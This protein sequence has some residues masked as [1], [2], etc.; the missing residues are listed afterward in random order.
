MSFPCPCCGFL[1]FKEEPCGNYEICPVCYWEDDCVQNKNPDYVGGANEISLNDAKKN[2][3]KY[4]AVQ[5]K[6]VKD[7]RDPFMDEFPNKLK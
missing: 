7:V 5:L 2:Y 6:F 4:G 3:T 1:T